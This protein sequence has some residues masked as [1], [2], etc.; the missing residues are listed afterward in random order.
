MTNLAAHPAELICRVVEHGEPAVI[1]P[2]DVPLGG[3]RAMTVRRTLPTRGRSFIG[4]WCFV[5]HYGP[6]DV[7][8]TGGMDVAPHPHIGL[9]TVSWLFA[10][11]IEHR[12]SLGTHAM[13]LPGEVNLMTAGWGI[14]HSEVSTPTT[15][16]LHGVQLWL[17][18]PAAHRTTAPRFEHYAPELLTDGAA[19]WRV[20]LGEI[21]GEK[22]PVP[23][24]APTLG[25]ELTL[26]A[27]G[28]I[29]I[30]VEPDF[31]HG[32]LVDTGSIQVD[33]TIMGVS[34]QLVTLPPGRD[35]VQ[36]QAAESARVLLL[37]GTPMDHDLVMWWNFV[38]GSHEE[39]VA[40]RD[41]WMAEISAAAAPRFGRVTGYDGSPLP[42]PVMPGG[43][44][45]ARKP[46]R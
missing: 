44:L 46:S 23:T 6:D 3:I 34:G 12:D 8:A 32:I 5:D 14:S 35:R 33:G 17:A 42:A 45:R 41:T 15:K 25:A 24:D 30:P 9:Q 13:V 28:V 36:V 11:E 29:D 31:E 43:T 20:F 10:G 26:A 38:G 19:Q 39:I 37:G 1:D 40:A 2:R 18:L 7:A 27:G 22:S 4:H 21:A 16:I